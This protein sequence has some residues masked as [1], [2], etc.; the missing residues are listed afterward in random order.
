[1]GQGTGLRLFV[2]HANGLGACFAPSL[3][4]KLGSGPAF[5]HEHPKPLAAPGVREETIFG[6]QGERQ[7]RDAAPR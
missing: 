1:M 6:V 4:R 2:R 3:L 7:L 5:S